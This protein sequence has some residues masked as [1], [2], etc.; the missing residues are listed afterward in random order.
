MAGCSFTYADSGKCSRSAMKRYAFC[1]GH[2]PD[3]AEVRSELA[4]KAGKSGGR[5]RPSF[6]RDE[7][8]RLQERFEALVDDLL[9]GVIER[10]DGAVAAQ[11]LN[12][13]R[14]CVISQMQAREHEE[15]VEEVRELH[16]QV[17][18]LEKTASLRR[19]K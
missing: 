9:A 12:G 7:L 18:S 4:S 15:L 2:R 5:G 16:E 17:A 8:V 1:F 11:L 6:V 10:G 13:A 14:A 19:V 3:L